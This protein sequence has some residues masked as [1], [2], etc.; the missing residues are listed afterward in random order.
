MRLRTYRVVCAALGAPALAAGA[1]SLAAPAAAGLPPAPAALARAGYSP[2]ALCPAPAPGRASCLGLRLVARAPL[3]VPGARAVPASRAAARSSSPAGP[4]LPANNL[5]PKSA[6][7]PTPATEYTK[8]LAASLK[9]NELLTA[10]GLPLSPQPASTQTIAIVDAYDDATA[11]ADLEHFDKQFGLPVCSRENGCF[12]KVNQAGEAAPLPPST[13]VEERGW[14][15]EIATDVEIAHSVCESCRIVLVEA[16]SPSYQNL[17]A[18]ENT[19]VALGATEVSNSWGGPEPP[20]DSQAFNHPGVVIAASSGDNGYLNW[21]E[22]LGSRFAEYPA[23]SPHVVAVGGTRLSISAGGAWEGETVW[24]DGG[25]NASGELEGHG[26]GGGGCSVPFTAPIWQRRLP[27]WSSVGCGEGRA[28]ADVAAVADPYTGVAVYDSTEGPAGERGWGM[29]GGTSVASPIIASVFGLAGGAHGVEYPAR[30]LYE[31]LEK[32]PASLHDIA[33]GSNGECLEPFNAAKGTSGC[34]STAEA[35]TCSGQAKCLAGP[36]YDGPSGVGTPNGI[37]AFQPAAQP[38]GGEKAPGGAG[39]AGGQGGGSGGAGAGSAGAGNAQA[40]GGGAG[41]P[42]GPSQGTTSAPPATGRGA[43]TPA[44]S[45][46]SLTRN[47]IVAL[48]RVR[49]R[50]SLVGFAF[51]ISAPAR[52]HVTLSKRVRLRGRPRWQVLPDS[53]T[54]TAVGGANRHRLAGHDTLTPGR[55]KLTLRPAHGAARSIVFLLG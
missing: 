29:I 17:E 43:Q 40:G 22:E 31:N 51:T 2:R 50:V 37:G 14:A 15:A 32:T 33:S 24:N 25:A 39:G 52:V 23:S 49:P 13:G 28:V 41:G 19:A 55:Y 11:E 36:G 10:Y 30:T 38:E 26:A 44:L 1:L 9:P 45:A 34:T 5:L 8:P 12:R 7:A 6:A 46:L 35:K 18:A 4:P 47:A 27:N 21:F 3:S 53:L 48:N 20:T 42:G 16:S 54:L